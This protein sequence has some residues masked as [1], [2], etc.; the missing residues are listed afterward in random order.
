MGSNMDAKEI[1]QTMLILVIGIFICFVVVQEYVCKPYPDIC[2]YGYAVL[3]LFIIS[4]I[5]GFYK[6]VLS[7]PASK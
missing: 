6:M 7:K 3:V 4:A 2:I 1:V 5:I